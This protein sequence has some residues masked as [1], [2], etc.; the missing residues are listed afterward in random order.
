ME[1]QREQLQLNLK[2]WQDMAT[3]CST[4][5]QK[6]RGVCVFFV[7]LFVVCGLG[8]FGRCCPCCLPLYSTPLTMSLLLTTV[9][10]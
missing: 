7:Y 8:T 3:Q 10:K 9:S 4:D 1:R 5:D 2:D 6:V